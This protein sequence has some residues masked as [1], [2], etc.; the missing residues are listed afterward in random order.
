MNVPFKGSDFDDN[1]HFSAGVM[2]DRE[3]VELNFLYETPVYRALIQVMYKYTQ[4]IGKLVS[5]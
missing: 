2:F 1:S 5:R 3:D 4:T